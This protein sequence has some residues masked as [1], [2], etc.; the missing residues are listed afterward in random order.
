MDEAVAKELECILGM[1]E[2]WKLDYMKYVA[3]ENDEYLVEDFLEELNQT[4][5]FPF[6]W[7]AAER[8]FLTRSEMSDFMGRCYEKVGELQ[9]AI[10][11]AKNEKSEL[12]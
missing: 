5:V 1:V 8:G 3:G 12:L 4:H 10:E 11:K 9:E 6:L 7:S 2:N